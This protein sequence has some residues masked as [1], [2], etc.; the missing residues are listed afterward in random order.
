MRSSQ[1]DDVVVMREI[2]RIRDKHQACSGRLVARGLRV[3]EIAVRLR[4]TELHKRGLVN[5]SP[6]IIGSVHLTPAGQRVIELADELAAEPVTPSVTE[7]AA[8]TAPKPVKETARK[9]GP[10]KKGAPRRATA[11]SRSTPR[12]E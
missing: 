7:P 4:I 9:R 8:D 1:L 3:P 2:Q 11:R 10:A 12:V 5:Y 6:R